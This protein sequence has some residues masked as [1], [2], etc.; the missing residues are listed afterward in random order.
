M[1][2]IPN[3]FDEAVKMAISD[4]LKHINAVA[5]SLFANIAA[6][7]AAHH[8]NYAKENSHDQSIID[9]ATEAYEDAAMD[10]YLLK[11]ALEPDYVSGNLCWNSGYQYDDSGNEFWVNVIYRPRFFVY[12]VLHH[13]EDVTVECGTH[14][15]L[16]DAKAQAGRIAYGDAIDVIEVDDIVACLPMY[17]DDADEL[18]DVEGELI[19]LK[20]YVSQILNKASHA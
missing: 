18:I 4:S 15:N 13:R 12:E 5:E 10:A 7:R 8:L 3:G 9:A 17:Q 1:L 19:S 2:N 16:N 20:D 6:E 14:R 11:V